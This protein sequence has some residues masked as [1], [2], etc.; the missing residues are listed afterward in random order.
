[1]RKFKA[2]K[3]GVLSNPYMRIRAG[4]V[5]TLSEDPKASWLVP[6]EDF[7]PE[8]ELPIVPHMTGAPVPQTQTPGVAPAPAG[9]QYN[10]GMETIVAKEAVE[11][12][13]VATLDEA[14]QNLQEVS[15]GKFVGD[16]VPVEVPAVNVV[17]EAQPETAGTGDQD[18]IG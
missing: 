1:M 5:V 7:V 12:G 10:R 2:T 3:P 18:V 4:D 13:K 14:K 15:P 16:A 6:V 8:P 17:A 11:D 9:D